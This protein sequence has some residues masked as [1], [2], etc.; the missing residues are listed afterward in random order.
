LLV[1]NLFKRARENPAVASFKLDLLFWL[2]IVPFVFLL[3]GVYALPVSIVQAFLVFTETKDR[4]PY[5]LRHFL[6]ILTGEGGQ[7]IAAFYLALAAL[8]AISWLADAI[9]NGDLLRAGLAL[10]YLGTIAFTTKLM[11]LLEQRRD[12]LPIFYLV[13]AQTD[14]L[15]ALASKE[16]MRLFAPENCKNL[17]F[18]NAI[19][20]DFLD[21]QKYGNL[22]ALLAIPIILLGIKEWNAKLKVPQDDGLKVVIALPSD[23]RERILKTLKKDVAKG[24]NNEGSLMTQI[25][26]A[27]VN[28][29]SGC[30]EGLHILWLDLKASSWEVKRLR[31]EIYDRLV[32]LRSFD[33]D[34]AGFNISTGTSTITAALAYLAIKD[35]ARIAYLTQNYESPEKAG[36]FL[37]FIH[38][39]NVRVADF[40]DLEADFLWEENS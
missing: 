6:K 34:T 14:N 19:P 37:R 27:Y 38:L 10:S 35:N 17:A 16:V 26:N 24:N 40:E 25:K 22:R 15:R 20:Q 30:I 21:R 13:S 33:F 2:S 5:N 18:R 3:L 11:A 36:G 28:F 31:N 32:R 23:T 12:D 9:W 4:G 29:L 1:T 39:E 7:H 8:L